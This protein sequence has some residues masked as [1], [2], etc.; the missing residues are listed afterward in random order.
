MVKNLTVADFYYI[1]FALLM[2]GLALIVIPRKTIRHLFGFSLVWGYLGSLFFIIVFGGGLFKLFYWR[3]S[4]P[5][6]FFQSPFLLNL[7]WVPAIMIYIYFLPKIKH[8][9]LLFLFSFAL[10]SAGLDEMFHRMGL[11]EYIH[12]HPFWRFIIAVVWLLGATIHYNRIIADNEKFVKD[13][14]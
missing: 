13:M 7:A 14:P 6:T 5:F 1:G 3:F 4:E 8:L 9:H 12:W 10:V 11:L 2:G